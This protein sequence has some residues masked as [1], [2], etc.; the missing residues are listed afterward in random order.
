MLPIPEYCQFSLMFKIQICTDSFQN[1]D[2]TIHVLTSTDLHKAGW[3]FLCN[4]AKLNLEKLKQYS[5][6]SS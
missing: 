3:A 5:C 2:P 6:F 1:C 4:A